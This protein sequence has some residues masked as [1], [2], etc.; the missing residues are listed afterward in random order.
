MDVPS[1]ADSKTLFGVQILNIIRKVMLTLENHMKLCGS[2]CVF[3]AELLQLAVFELNEG[4]PKWFRA[5]IR[6]K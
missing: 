5:G 3:F 1:H 2:L 6:T 4:Q